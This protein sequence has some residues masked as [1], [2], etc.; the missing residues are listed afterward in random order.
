MPVPEPGEQTTTSEASTTTEAST[1]STTAE[2]TT[3]TEPD[4][5]GTSPTTAPELVPGEPPPPDP[6]PGEPEPPPEGQEPGP[7]ADD[8]APDGEAPTGAGAF[9]AELK[10]MMDSVKRTKANST[11]ALLTALQPLVDLGVPT[12]EIV[13]VGFG[14]FPVGG[15]AK[16][17]HD[18]WFPRFGPG[19]RLHQGTDIFAPYGTPVRSPVDGTVRLSNGGLGGTT[20][21]VTQADGG[22]VYLAH[23][24]G[25]PAGLTDGQQ[26]KV[27]DV[28][29]YVGDS[30]NA[31]G[32]SPHTHFE[33]HPAPYKKVTVGRGKA[34]QQKL[35]PVPVAR[36]T[37]LPAVDPKAYLDQ[38]L[39]EAIANVPSLIAQYETARPRALLA[40]G[41]TR[42]FSGERTSLFEAPG[43]PP[44]AQLLWASAVNPE[45]GALAL[46]EAEARTAVRRAS[47]R[48]PPATVSRGSW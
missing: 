32:S 17:S 7:P 26:V 5:E 4:D 6:P 10:A 21:Y 33:L 40:T 41:M 42:R 22:Y 16:Y 18:W 43:R 39:A 25:H 24:S 38:W 2:A 28:V 20:T 44:Q 45:A 8:T 31:R 12:E 48:G 30:G 47:R 36:G 9:P 3:T 29:G 13:R 34:A 46:A 11:R 19:W 15:E 27:G 35:V 1:T 37:K 14:R 23:L